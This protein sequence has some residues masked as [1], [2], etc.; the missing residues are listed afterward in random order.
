MHGQPDDHQGIVLPLDGRPGGPAPGPPERNGGRRPPYVGPP[1]G[2]A[3]LLSWEPA[4]EADDARG[5]GDRLSASCELARHLV[6][7]RAPQADLAVRLAL[8]EAFGAE[9]LLRLVGA[10]A[11]P[12]GSGPSTLLPVG[13]P[14][15]GPAPGAPL[16][17]LVLSVAVEIAA[18]GTQSRVLD[19]ITSAAAALAPAGVTGPDSRLRAAEEALRAAQND[20]LEHGAVGAGTGLD[21]AIANLSVLRHQT[22]AR[23]SGW[24]RVAAAA[25]PAGSPGIALREQ[26]GEV[27]KLGWDG[28][29]AAVHGAYQALVLDARRILL[30][31]ADQLLRSPSRPLAALRPLIEPDLAGRA[32][33][34]ARLHRLLGTLSVLP[35][36]VR[37][38]SGGMLPNLIAE[39]AATN[40]RTQALFTRMANALHPPAWCG[41]VAVE[42]RALP[43]GELQILRP[44]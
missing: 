32:S 5:W 29:P 8:P 7:P 1:P 2:P 4:A 18:T 15:S 31:A 44:A 27:G 20:L 35:L 14:G 39:Q 41:R 13:A 10:E 37:K 43:S 9:P 42:V 6:R 19:A 28:F 22:H 33:D 11:P 30:S 38:R 26:L 16:G 34:I 17:A 12:A 24:E 25:D 21:T 23:L 3:L 40:A 36:T